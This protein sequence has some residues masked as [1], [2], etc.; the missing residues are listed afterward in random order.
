MTR[1]NGNPKAEDDPELLPSSST[2]ARRL[3]RR[4]ALEPMV[5]RLRARG[6]A[7]SNSFEGALWTKNEL[8][9]IKALASIV[10]EKKKSLCGASVLG[11]RILDR[12]SEAIRRKIDYWIHYERFNP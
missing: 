5:E 11:K 12:S 3:E 7:R 1:K 2:E 4:K 8:E 9:I 10:R 6:R